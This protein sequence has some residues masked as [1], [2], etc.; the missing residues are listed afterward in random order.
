LKHV[1]IFLVCFIVLG[2]SLSCKAVT[3]AAGEESEPAIIQSTEVPRPQAT[4]ASL[5]VPKPGGLITKVIL[6]HGAESETYDPIDPAT[7]FLPTDTVHAIVTVKKAPVDT[8]FTAKWFTTKIEL[9][10]RDNELID[11]TE[12]KTEGTGNLDFTLAP[13]GKFPTGSYRVEIYVNNNLDQVKAYNVA[14]GD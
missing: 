4:K 10:G 3:G 9:D 8:L 1:R 6:A 2:V 13:Q 7:Q 12:I 11:T 14:A 5:P